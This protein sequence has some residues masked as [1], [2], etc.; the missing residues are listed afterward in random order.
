MADLNQLTTHGKEKPG[1]YADNSYDEEQASPEMELDHL[2]M[3]MDE[4]DFDEMERIMRENMGY[5]FKKDRK[6][7]SL[8]DMVQ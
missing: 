7:D 5:E 4:E 2:A 6:R 3:D 1:R 8:L